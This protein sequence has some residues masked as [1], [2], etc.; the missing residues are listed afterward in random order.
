MRITVEMDNGQSVVIERDTALV[1]RMVKRY[2]EVSMLRVE[3][4]LSE[5]SQ[6]VSKGVINGKPKKIANVCEEIVD[7]LEHTLWVI[8]RFGITCEQLQP[9]ENEKGPRYVER[10]KK[11]LNIFRTEEARDEYWSHHFDPEKT[12]G[13]RTDGEGH[14]SFIGLKDTDAAGT[15]AA[16]F[17]DQLQRLRR[18]MV[19]KGA[20]GA[21]ILHMPD[22]RA[23]QYVAN[24]LNPGST[25]LGYMPSS[26][27]MQL[28]AGHIAPSDMLKSKMNMDYRDLIPTDF[29]QRLLSEKCRQSTQSSGDVVNELLSNIEYIIGM[30]RAYKSS[31]SDLWDWWTERLAQI[32]RDEHGD[33]DGAEYLAALNE[34]KQKLA[35]YEAQKG[36]VK[37]GTVSE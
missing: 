31:V 8:A 25:T 29:A 19:D 26:E 2:P 17:F 23:L 33:L 28:L 11:D 1:T 10:E 32:P 3:E 9:W 7:V 21:S 15:I 16:N 6:A 18:E 20:I 34:Y 14:Y 36:D 27:R 4:E 37:D 5:L 13:F 24:A 30:R 22:I 12:W 35:E